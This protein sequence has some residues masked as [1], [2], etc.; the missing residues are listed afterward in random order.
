VLFEECYFEEEI[1]YKK[2]PIKNCY[3]I[4]K[5]NDEVLFSQSKWNKHTDW[6][7]TIRKYLK[8][9]SNNLSVHNPFYNGKF[10]LQI[11]EYSPKIF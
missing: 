1:F 11:E 9:I 8:P 4:F 6:S 3:S 7:K 5:K 2:I 10:T